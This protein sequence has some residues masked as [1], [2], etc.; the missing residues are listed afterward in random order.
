MARRDH[1]TEAEKEIE[2][3][4]ARH[5]A[6]LKEQGRGGM[7]DAS[8][9]QARIRKLHDVHQISFQR[10]A[11]KTGVDLANVKW[12]YHG[13]SFSRPSDPLT[14][15]QWRTHNAIM[16]TPFGPADVKQDIRATG[17]QRRLRALIAVGYSQKW[18]A[19]ATGRS[20]EH[21]N[22][23]LRMDAEY[24]GAEHAAMVEQVYRKYAH[25]DPAEVGIEQRIISYSR[26][27]ARKRK[28]HPPLCWDEDTIDDPAALPEYTGACG[29]EEGYRIHVRETI[30]EGNPLPPCDACRDAVETVEYVETVIFK[31]ERFAELLKERNIN[32]R[33]LAIKMYGV[34]AE[35]E[36]GI[37]RKA[38]VLYRWRDGSRAP[39]TRGQVHALASALDAPLG[40]L[41]DE[42]AT[43][44]ASTRPRVGNGQFNP[45]ILRAA[46]EMAGVSFSGTTTFPGAD[47]SSA[48]VAKWVKGEM[49]PS[50][51]KK[52]KPIADHFGVGVE[53]FYQ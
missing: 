43:E 52:L 1:L 25:T 21:L 18:L 41:L 13:R 9:M 37:R 26:T 36:I 2:R 8:E 50:D 4:K 15:C 23:F 38:D 51:P 11:E 31:R 27:V 42:E 49:R 34:D 12:H 28:F 45:H 29:T 32:A 17:T 19:E 6:Y 44:R 47:Y 46:L 48:A 14:Q 39:K 30:F 16:T 5:R 20:L 35:D 33:Q 22:H 7:V 24:V 3:A 53:V 10:I 40:D